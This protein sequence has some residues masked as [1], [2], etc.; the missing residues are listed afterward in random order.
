MTSTKNNQFF[1]PTHHPPPSAKMKNRS[2]TNFETSHQSVASI[3]VCRSSCHNSFMIK[4]RKRKWVRENVFMYLLFFACLDVH[5][6]QLLPIR[7]ALLSIHILAYFFH[8]PSPCGPQ[9]ECPL[10]PQPRRSPSNAFSIYH[11]NLNSISPRNHPEV[12]LN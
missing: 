10:N 3:E 6:C 11:W 5:R 1:D 4:R 9:N 8:S 12:F 2:V 7:L